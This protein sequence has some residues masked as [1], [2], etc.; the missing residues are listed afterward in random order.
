MTTPELLG[1]C[2]DVLARL[3]AERPLVHN[4]TNYVAMDISANA[5]LAAG[6]KPAA[7]ADERRAGP[8]CP[9]RW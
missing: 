8:D 4:I 3:R 6:D 7:I 9:L 2:A 1:R 5:L